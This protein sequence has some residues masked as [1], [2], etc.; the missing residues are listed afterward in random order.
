MSATTTGS[1][2]APTAA[3]RWG[4]L[5]EFH[6]V[7]SLLRAARL[8]RESGLTRWDAHTPFPV[9]GL[10]GAMGVR[11]TRLPWFVFVAGLTGTLTGF[12]L[13]SWTSAVDY[14]LV[15]SGKPLVSLPAF[16]PIAFELTI[17]FAAITAL[18][19][20]LIGN[21]LPELYHPLF[22]VPEFA[23]ATDDRFFISIQADDPRLDRVDLERLVTTL[24]PESVREVSS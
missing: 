20:M 12:A 1:A 13:Q 23:R 16:V 8:V 22:R 24:G 2:G 21:R 11:S 19:G 4:W 6:D 18:V 9:H 3:A 15:I 5:L 10:D 17:L 14:P 7:T